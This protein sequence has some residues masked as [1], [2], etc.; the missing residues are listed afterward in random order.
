LSRLTPGAISF[1]FFKITCH[2]LFRPVYR[3]SANLFHKLVR[4]FL[5]GKP[6]V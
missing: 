5:F 6:P 2:R 4:M 1:R 3:L